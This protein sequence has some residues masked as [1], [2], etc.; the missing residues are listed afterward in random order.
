MLIGILMIVTAIFNLLDIDM[1]SNA[2]MLLVFKFY[3]V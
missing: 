2:I 1:S 3:E